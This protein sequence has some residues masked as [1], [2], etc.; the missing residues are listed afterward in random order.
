LAL[1]P[2]APAVANAIH[3][4]VGVWINELPITSEKVLQALQSKKTRGG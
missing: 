2:A 4:A 3:D 1:S